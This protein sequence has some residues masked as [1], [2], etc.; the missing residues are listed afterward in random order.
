MFFVNVNLLA[1]LVCVN[2]LQCNPGYEEQRLAYTLF[3]LDKCFI[4]TIKYGGSGVSDSEGS[5][6]THLAGSKTLCYI[7]SDGKDGYGTSA[8]FGRLGTAALIPDSTTLIVSDLP[9]NKLR[10][11]DHVTGEVITIINV[12]YDASYNP[13]YR[14]G[15]GMGAAIAYPNVLTVSRSPVFF[16]VSDN[17]QMRKVTY[18][19]VEVS[20]VSFQSYSSYYRKYQSLSKDGTFM[21]MTDQINR[22]VMKYDIVLNQMSTLA[23]TSGGLWYA[24]SFYVCADGVGNNVRLANPTYSVI[25]SLGSVVYIS[26]CYNK[27]NIRKINMATLQVSSLVGTCP[28]YTARPNPLNI[29]GMVLSPDESRLIF[30]QCNGDLSYTGSKVCTLNYVDVI[31]GVGKVINPSSGPV[32]DFSRVYFLLMLPGETGPCEVCALGKY[33]PDGFNCNT[34]PSGFFCDSSSSMQCPV[35]KCIHY[36]EI[37]IYG[38]SWFDM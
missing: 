12:V 1:V 29:Q 28:D 16:Y 7:N 23:G 3:V 6:F 26:D 33:S 22:R 2:S 13:I 32:Y 36:F 19:N 14:D 21:I 35:G 10:T 17:Y 4:Q 8:I 11:V 31:T 24:N 37:I 15:I 20:T 30:I 27:V 38:C 34:C 5:P 9:A 18:P 25:D